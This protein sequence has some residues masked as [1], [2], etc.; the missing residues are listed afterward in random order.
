MSINESWIEQVY[1]QKGFK[2]YVSV[3]KSSNCTVRF[4]WYYILKGNVSPNSFI[5]HLTCIQDDCLLHNQNVAD[6]INYTTRADAQQTSWLSPVTAR[7]TALT[8][9]VV[10]SPSFGRR[11]P[12]LAN[13]IVLIGGNE[14]IMSP[15]LRNLV[16]MLYRGDLV[17]IRNSRG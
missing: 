14:L 15:R 8:S 3:T 9:C 16:H 6:D 4:T 10:N 5:L 11:E 1:F 13:S 17:L 12:N 2:S 7:E